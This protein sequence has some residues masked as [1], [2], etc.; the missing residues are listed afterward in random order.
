MKVLHASV[1]SDPLNSIIFH[2]FEWDWMNTW[3]NTHLH[4]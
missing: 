2:K 1:A 3:R 4:V